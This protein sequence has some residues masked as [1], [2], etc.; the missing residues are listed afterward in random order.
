MSLVNGI[1]A[2][3]EGFGANPPSQDTAQDR[4]DVCTGRTSGVPCPNN[5]RGGF[6]LTAQASA[7][8]HVQRQRKLDLKLNVDGEE[9]LG[10]CK[11][12]GCYL[13]L[14]VWYDSETISSHTT[15]ETFSR[16]PDFCWIKHLKTQP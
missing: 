15:D 4:S 6:S 7:I 9:S 11:V 3:L 5:H 14:K 8:I 2:I 1:E 13:P 16:F 10:I 12:C